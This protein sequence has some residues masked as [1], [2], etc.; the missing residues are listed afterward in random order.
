[1]KKKTVLSMFL[2]IAVCTSAIGETNWPH[3]LG[4]NRNATS[5][6]TGLLRE[7][8]ESGPKVVWSFPLGAGYGAPAV[9]DGKVYILD[10]VNNQ[11]D[12]LRCLDLE[13]GREEWNFAYDAPGRFGHPGSRSVPTVDKERIYTCGPQGDIYCV[14]KTTYKPIWNKSLREGFGPAAS[15]NWGFGQNP[16][17]NENMLIIAPMTSE[18]GVAALNPET[19]DVIWKTPPLSGGPG[20]VSPTVINIDGEYQIVMINAASRG[21]RGR[22]GTPS[23]SQQ[24]DTTTI[25][26]MVGLNP[27]TGA[28][29]WKYDG[30]QCG[31]P[32]PNVATLGDGRL[33]ITG[34][35]QAGSAMI[36][37]SKKDQ[38][39]QVEEL[40][41]TSEFGLH[42]HPPALYKD[43]FYGHCTTNETR[44]GMV[45]MTVD[46][47]V[48]WK[49]GNSPLFDKG[50]MLLVDGLIITT[51]GN[52]GYLYLIDPTPEGFKPLAQAKMLEPGEN[53]APLTLVDGKLLIRDQTQIKCVLVK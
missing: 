33:F 26:T 14:D 23:S 20:Y 7:W 16:L 6:E 31:I 12:I 11:Q 17:L 2:V 22:R 39:Y 43:H 8:P 45:C 44:D 5:D 24:S 18:T 9:V 1:M 13:T 41:K 36:R 27:K 52:K 30:W 15:L 38:T 40:Y 21:S 28:P 48:L 3:Y 46:G 19:G 29:L 51:D 37:V 53:W 4:P 35:Y 49:T 25:G 47:K 42:V 10:N 50:G 34:G 32:I